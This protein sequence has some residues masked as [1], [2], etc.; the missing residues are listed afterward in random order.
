MRANRCKTRGS[1][2]LMVIGAMV[3]CLFALLHSLKSSMQ[4]RHSQARLQDRFQVHNLSRSCLEI[5]YN[6][7]K[8]VS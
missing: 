5:S 4:A 7:L 3:L 8:A 2:Y 6:Q 1:A